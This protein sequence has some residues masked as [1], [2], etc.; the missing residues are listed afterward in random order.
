MQQQVCNDFKWTGNNVDKFKQAFGKNPKSL[1]E[2]KKRQEISGKRG[3]IIVKY[4]VL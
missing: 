1:L 2:L 4:K 3:K